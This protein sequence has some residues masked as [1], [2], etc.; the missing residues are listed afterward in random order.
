L[1]EG[2][3]PS[4]ARGALALC[5]L[6]IAACAFAEDDA[7]TWLTLMSDALATRSYEGEFVHLAPGGQE[8][9][10]ILHRVAGNKVSERLVSLTGNRREI[11]RDDSGVYCYLPDQ[12]KVL[13][14]SRD[15][16]GSLLASP[17]RFDADLSANYELRLV[18]RFKSMIGPYAKVVLVRPRDAYR[19]GYRLWIDEGS[20]LPLRTDLCDTDGHVLE[21]VVYMRLTPDKA[22]SAEAMRPG[23][24]QAGLTWERQASSAAAPEPWH[25]VHVPAGFALRSAVEE[26]MPG[27]GQLVTHLVLS[28]GLAAVSVFIETATGHRGGTSQGRVGSAVAYSTVVSGHLITAVGTVPAAT[29][30]AIV[31]G[32]ESG[33]H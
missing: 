28:D 17:P 6:G 16:R 15:E 8:R 3:A 23:I 20:H 30:A 10:R 22:L 5:A 14:R 1:S 27:E 4:L 18:G 32:I 26:Q 31:G 12:H 21:Q 29:V 2:L 24:A 7:R 11:I 9:I 13:F 33:G 25:T 19:Y